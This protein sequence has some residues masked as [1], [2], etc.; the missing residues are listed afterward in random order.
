MS[1]LLPYHVYDLAEEELLWAIEQP[2]VP[3]EWCDPEREKQAEKEFIENFGD[4]D[5]LREFLKEEEKEEKDRRK[6]RKRESQVKDEEEEEDFF[7][8]LGWSSKEKGKGKERQIDLEE[9]EQAKIKLEKEEDQTQDS[10]IDDEEFSI[11][12]SDYHPY[13]LSL[14]LSFHSRHSKLSDRLRDLQ[15]KSQTSHLDSRFQDVSLVQLERLALQKDKDLYAE[16]VNELKELKLEALKLGIK[17]PGQQPPIQ[18]GYSQSPSSSQSQRPS[19]TVQSWNGSPQQQATG[20]QAAQTNQQIRNPNYTNN[21]VHQN[22]TSQNRSNLPQSQPSSS[23]QTQ[24]QSQNPS[25]PSSSS[26]KPGS[27]SGSGNSIPSHPIPLQIPITHLSRLTNLGIVPIPLPHLIPILP[28]SQSGER[29]EIGE[30]T[31]ARNPPSDQEHAAMLLGITERENSDGLGNTQMLNISV[32]LTKFDPKQLSGLA[33][34]MQELQD[35]NK[36]NANRGG[37]K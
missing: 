26:Q 17:T 4:G 36:G 20:N 7:K 35:G 18:P 33:G 2:V 27:G 24:S 11:P 28:K 23:N 13:P 16:R 1:R 29:L 30:S 34:L 6:K 21:Q 32:V 15:R 22:P 8:S 31:R 10:G 5:G 25:N 12:G 19:P 37:Q 3:Q 9:D 14:A